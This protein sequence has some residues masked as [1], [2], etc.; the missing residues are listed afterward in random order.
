M[1][2][3][4]LL[5]G[6]NQGNSKA[7]LQEAA[8][9][10][11]NT[12]GTITATSAIYRT[13]AWGV[14]DQPDFLNQ[15]IAIQTSLSAM[16]LLTA[17]QTIEATLGRQRDVKWGPRTLDIDMLFFNDDIINTPELVVPHP[18][19]HSRRFTLVPLAEIAPKKLHPV[20]H[21]NITEL[22][23]ACPDKLEVTKD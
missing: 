23:E 14:S 11:G 22:L 10:I 2:E 21:R 20:L 4:Y 3:S 12:C 5:L 9:L 6:S 7:L 8:Q 17:I 15:V 19:L 16:Q 18:Y 1:N 13:A